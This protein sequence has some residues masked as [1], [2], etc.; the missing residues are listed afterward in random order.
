MSKSNKQH[1]KGKSS[2]KGGDRHHKASSSSYPR[3]RNRFTE[4]NFNQPQEIE[5]EFDESGEVGVDDD[6]NYE[7]L[8]NLTVNVCLWEFGQ[9]DPNR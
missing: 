3:S 1:S 2:S 8:I 7:D 5:N 9:N 6:V 4:R